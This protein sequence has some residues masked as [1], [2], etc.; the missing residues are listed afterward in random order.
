M[1]DTSATPP[2]VTVI[3]PTYNWS[4]VLPYC[5][6]SVLRQTFT[7]FELLVVGDCCTDDSAQVV[8][9]IAD[10]RVRWINLPVNHGHQTGPNNEG[11]RQARGSIIAYLGH[12]DLWLPHHLEVLVKAIDGGASVAHSLVHLIDAEG[13]ILLPNQGML[14]HQPG[15]TMPPT[16]VVHLRLA[17]ET[18]GGWP[19]YHTTSLD[20]E[21]DLWDRM[22]EAGFVFQSVPRLTAVKFPASARK[23]VYKKRS[24]HEQRHWTERILHEVDLEAVEFGKLLLMADVEVPPTLF[25]V[26]FRK[27]LGKASP[28]SLRGRCLFFIR[29]L[30]SSGRLQPPASGGSIRWTQKF[31]GLDKP[32]T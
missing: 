14:R 30:L 8:A 31:K 6:G 28:T 23:D 7:D 27:L 12:D 10:P 17:S 13:N 11:I 32:A 3:I 25:S 15:L 1:P 21:T 18:V 2:R 5:I 22:H 19:D 26:A 24:S 4:T 16:S 20:P 9:T 29:K